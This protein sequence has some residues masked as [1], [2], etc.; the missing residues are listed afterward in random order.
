MIHPLTWI[1]AAFHLEGRRLEFFERACRLI[2]V[3]EVTGCWEWLGSTSGSSG[4]GKDYAR[5]S[6]MGQTV[7]MHRAMWVTFHGY[8][9][10]KKQLDHVCRNRKCINPFPDHTE[11]VT[12]W[13][14]CQRRDAAIKLGKEP[15][16]G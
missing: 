8:L 12:H 16:H 14:N 6:W 11:P 1:P 3:N 10:G 5:A 4:R 2:H 15:D 7:A 13:Q 9:P